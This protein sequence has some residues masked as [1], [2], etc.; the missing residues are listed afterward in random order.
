MKITEVNVFQVEGETRAGLALYETARDG[1]Q[2]GQASPYRTT[3]T[4]IHTDDG[5]IGL[6]QGGSPE[7]KAAGQLLIGE[8]PMRVEYL[9]EKLFHTGAPRVA[10]PV[11]ARLDLALW[12]LI[13]KA[14][15]E[16]VYRLLGGPMRKRVRAYAAMLGFSIEP[17]AAARRSVELVEQGFTALK[18][19]LPYGALAGAEGMRH[20]VALIRDVRRAVGDDV[21]VMVDCVLAHSHANSRLYA[22]ELAR[23]LEEFQPTWLEEPLPFD[24]LDAYAALARATRIPIAFG[25]HNYDRW[26]F[27]RLIESG[28]PSVLQPDANAAGGI[29]EM[30][31]I[32][33]LASTYSVPVVP[34][35]NESCRNAAHLL[36]AQ[37]E[38]VCPLGEWAVKGNANFQYFYADR[39]APVNGYFEPPAGPGFGY[40]LDPARI[41]RRIDL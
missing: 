4:T 38:R 34:H 19:Y 5:L 29:T 14:K 20:N 3:F 40:D 10:V 21:Q 23:R 9:W 39:Y 8:D 33:A 6:T 36:F 31:K 22:I 16:P 41:V 1:L 37:P 35:A 11:I 30:R 27:R 15:G 7:I 13:G 28:A 24:D 17:E 18:W 25:E 32:I 26:Q 12:D 2:P